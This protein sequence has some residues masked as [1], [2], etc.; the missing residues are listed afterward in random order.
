MNKYGTVLF[1]GLFDEAYDC[2]DDI[3]VDDVLN[4]VFCPIEGEKAHAFNS[5]IILTMS[6]CTINDMSDL[7]EG[8]PFNVL[9][10]QMQYMRYD[11]VSHENRISYFDW[12]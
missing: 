10:L 6:A 11:V 3:L 4:I 1:F 5:G 7:V 2:V 12:N 8:Q 9:D